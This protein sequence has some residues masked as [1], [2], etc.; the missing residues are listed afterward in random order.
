[1]QGGAYEGET[2]SRKEG[3]VMSNSIRD[4]VRDKVFAARAA[5]ARCLMIYDP[6][7]RYRDLA[8]ALAGDSREVIDVAGSIIE[9]RE[10]AAEALARLAQGVTNSVIVWA[11]LAKPRD[12]DDKQK[13]PFAVFAEVGDVF[14]KGDGDEYA[15]ICRR[16]KPD[17][18]AEINRLFADGIPSFDMVDALDAGGSWPKLRTL[19]GVSSAREIL[20]AFLSPTP[21]QADALKDDGAWSDELRDFVV[22]TLGYKFK[23]KGITRQPLADELWRLLLFSELVFDSSGEI[24]NG[25]EG[26]ARAGNEAKEM[27]F[28]VCTHLRKYDD[29]KESYK[30]RAEEVEKEL[31]L[32][33][34]IRVMKQLGT[35]DT[36]ACE[37]RAFFDRMVELAKNQQI[38]AAKEICE[39]R[40]KSIW[41]TREDRLAE[42]TLADR[43][44]DLL[45]AVGLSSAARFPSLEAMIGH[46]STKGRDL[47]RFHRELEQ[48]ANQ[49]GE[50]HEGVETL[51][52]LSRNAYTKAAEAMQAEFV[53]LVQAEAWPVTNGVMLSNRKLFD[54]KVAPFLEAGKKVAYFLVDSLRYELAV[55]IEKQLLDRWRVELV[56][57]CAQLPSYTEIGMASLMPEAESALSL[58]KESDTLVTTLAGK[59]ATTPATRFSYLVSRKG[60]QCAD[61]DLDELL[62]QKRPRFPDT[63]R[64]LVVRTRDI[65]VLAHQSPR[66][67]LEVMPGLLRQIIQGLTKVAGLGFEHAVIATDHGFLFLRD[68][69]PGNVVPKPPGNWLVQKSRCLLGE[70]EANAHTL[71]F[72]AADMGIPGPVRNYAV[73]RSLGAFVQGELYYHEGLS[74]QECV[75]PCM[76]I[77]LVS[78]EKPDRVVAVPRLSLNYKQGRTDKITTRRPVLDLARVQELFPEASD[79]EFSV[80]AFDTSGKLVGAAAGGQT[81]NPATGCVRVKPGEVISVSLKMDDDFVGSFKVRVLDPST[82]AQYAELSLKTDYLE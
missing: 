29:Y 71:V 80:E 42:W 63:T 24:P 1:M 14:P 73:P 8:V 76:T 35:R 66:H 16:A 58:A 2:G 56:P 60:D 31:Q 49:V 33:D 39:S 36:F 18:I 51:L 82:G 9:Q 59:S 50:H 26:V 81:V 30:T 19:L 38:D 61:C 13:D 54:R 70:G 40:R 21:K 6:D 34:R 32:P 62:K 25:L 4:F 11:P 17:H 64:L 3:D 55:E 52:A 22:R 46:Y 27:V 41:L 37:E 75:V 23:T 67:V 69:E 47:D 28:D 45:S 53:R 79:R 74:L 48:A 15:A 57:S 44:L 7:R 77:E 68:N 65:D 43:A 20:V 5:E 78:A 72:K 12:A 10:A